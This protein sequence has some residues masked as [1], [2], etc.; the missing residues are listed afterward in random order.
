[1]YQSGWHVY[2]IV[3]ICYDV[4]YVYSSTV[5]SDSDMMW[6]LWMLIP[7][8]SSGST[9]TKSQKKQK[10]TSWKKGNKRHRSWI[11]KQLIGLIASLYPT[12]NRCPVPPPM[13][14]LKYSELFMGKP[15]DRLD[16][17]WLLNIGFGDHRITKAS[18]YQLPN[19]KQ[20]VREL[21]IMAIGDGK[22]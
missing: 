7:M 13:L 17:W 1:M 6:W 11:P 18:G 3:L 16:C 5:Y 8:N 9:P 20:Q 19:P 12:Q 2:H 10:K 4:Q 22:L 21:C 15:R 14:R